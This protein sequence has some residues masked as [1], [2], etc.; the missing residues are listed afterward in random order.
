MTNFERMRKRE[1]NAVLKMY[2]VKK[3]G[4][5]KMSTNDE[6]C[7]YTKEVRAQMR[8]AGFKIYKDGKIYKE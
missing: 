6:K 5:L 4:V 1:L 3:D 8:K 7:L 2:E